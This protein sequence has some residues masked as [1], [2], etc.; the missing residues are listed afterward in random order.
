MYSSVFKGKAIKFYHY[1]C[2]SCAF[3]VCFLFQIYAM[4]IFQ[5]VCCLIRGVA[6]FNYL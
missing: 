6:E 2:I 5:F 3:R 4:Y 1:F